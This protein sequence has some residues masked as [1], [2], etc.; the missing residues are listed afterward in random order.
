M[1]WKAVKDHY[2]VGHLVSI[3][4]GKGICIGSSYVHDLIRIDPTAR[5]VQWGNLGPSRNDD[6]ARYWEE[7]HADLAAF[8]RLVNAPD[9]FEKDL[10]VFTYEGGEVVKYL[11]EEY[12]WPNV[13]HDGQMMYENTF[14]PNAEDARA[15]GI[16][17]AKARVENL[18]ETVKR[19][20]DDLAER[21]NWLAE[22]K[23]DLA[24]IQATS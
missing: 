15:A 10:P 16:R 1:G 3:H 8:W 22:S 2:R 20:E 21:R 18:Q 23:A 14:F 11:C 17:N 19:I 24:K 9:V 4:T 7:M 12:G 6:L 5:T 13:T